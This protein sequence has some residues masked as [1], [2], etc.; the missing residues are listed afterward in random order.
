MSLA[1]ALKAQRGSLHLEVELRTEPGEVVAILGPNG[2]GKS[3]LLHV[4]AGLLPIVDG[5]VVLDGDVLDDVAAGVWVPP[6]QRSIGVVFQDYLLFPHLSVLENVAFGLVGRGQAHGEARRR[7]LQWLDRV[8]LADHASLKPAELSGGQAQRVALVRALAIEPRLLLLDEPLS[9]LDVSSRAEVRRT[10]R[11]HLDDF[12]GIRLLVTHDPLEA[13]MLANRIMIL[14]GGRIIQ[15]GTPAEIAE[16]PRTP[17]VAD[18]AGVNLLRG[19]AAGDRIELHGGGSLAVADAGS[20]EVFAVIHPR[21]V[22]LHRRAPE[23][24]PRNVWHGTVAG[25]DLEGPRVRVRVAAEIPIVAEIT[26][27]AVAELHLDQGVE[28]WVSVKATEINTYPT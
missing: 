15:S 28:V 1:A 12:K 10:L 13:M 11:R 21:A 18:L 14:E 20:G 16:K 3:T 25:L 8:G 17:Y 2:A 7:A 4:L 23:G 19:R 5:R 22:A 26:P 27:A 24:T 9:A 6:E